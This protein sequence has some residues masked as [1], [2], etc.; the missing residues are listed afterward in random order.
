MGGDVS[1]LRVEWSRSRLQLGFVVRVVNHWTELAVPDVLSVSVLN[2]AVEPVGGPGRGRQRDGT[3]RFLSLPAG[4]YSLEISDPSLNW[5]FFEGLPTVSLPLS[6]PAAEAQ[7][8][9]VR[10]WP[11]PAR[12][13]PAATTLIRG[14]LRTA[15]GD[16]VVGVKVAVAPV[17]GP[18]PKAAWTDSDGE[19]VC[20]LSTYLKPNLMGQLSLEAR[21]EE[22]LR[23]V[24]A[25]RVDA[26]P[27]DPG[28]GFLISPS[29]ASRVRFEI[30]S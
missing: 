22:G 9:E 11:T 18:W 24:V 4:E 21:V 2:G 30:L 19:F 26:A 15:A 7:V 8:I 5:A 3:Y 16:P 27:P 28:P 6:D 17:G 23:V 12:A 13:T 1:A 25:S 20:Q 10:A 14:S 29:R